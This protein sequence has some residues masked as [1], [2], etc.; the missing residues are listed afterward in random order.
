MEQLTSFLPIILVIGVVIFIM[1]RLNLG[2]KMRCNRCDGTGRVDERWP[3][4]NK[5]G[6]WH[7]LAGQCPKCK[8]KGTISSRS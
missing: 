6:G 8:G 5:P 1:S 7:V 2:P 3:A 4:P